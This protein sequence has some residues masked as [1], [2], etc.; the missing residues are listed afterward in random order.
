MLVCP[1]GA[2]SL[3]G[4]RMIKC[5]LCEGDPQCVK[6]CATKA[7]EFKPIDRARK[8]LME[9]KAEGILKSFKGQRK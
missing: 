2:I 1:F 7:L 4:D 8:S 6:W 3:D 9:R 5:D